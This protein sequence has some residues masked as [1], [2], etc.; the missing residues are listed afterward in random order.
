MAIISFLNPKGG[1]GKTTIST[2]VARAFHDRGYKILLVDS[3]PQGS[4][5]DW[6][7]AN[8][9]N[10]VP[11]VAL[12]RANNLKTLLAVGQGYHHVFIDGAAKLQDMIAAAIRISDVVIIPVQPSPYDV[13]AA[14]DL[15]DLIKARQEIADGQPR[16]AFVITR[17]IQHT[18]LGREISE[19][20]EAHSFPVFSNC[21][22]QRQIYPQ[23]ASNGLT[24]FDSANSAAIQEITAFADELENFLNSDR[25]TQDDT[26]HATA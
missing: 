24:V 14:S 26:Q 21:T 22:V 7:A 10:P 6:H 19:A 4:A 3:D 9:K 20:L 11:L 15:V 17:A 12:D 16:S 1:S 23:T 5:R 13:W 18:R 8:D 25:G 2:N